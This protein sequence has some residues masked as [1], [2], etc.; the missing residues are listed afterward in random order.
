MDGTPGSRPRFG[1]P[2]DRVFPLYRIA[3]GGLFLEEYVLLFDDNSGMMPTAFLIPYSR[4]EVSN[5][6]N[7]QRR[8]ENCFRTSMEVTKVSHLLRSQ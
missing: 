7:E 5:T 1:K 6:Y 2:D 4:W 8:L 3:S